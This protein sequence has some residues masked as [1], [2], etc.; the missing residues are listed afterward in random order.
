MLTHPKETGDILYFSSLWK[1]LVLFFL[2][3]LNAEAPLSESLPL[4]FWSSA[5]GEWAWSA[6]A[7]PS[8]YEAK[9]ILCYFII[10][11]SRIKLLIVWWGLL[12]ALSL[13]QE[14]QYYVFWK[15]TSYHYVF[16]KVKM[17]HFHQGSPEFLAREQLKFNPFCGILSFHFIFLIRQFNVLLMNSNPREPANYFKRL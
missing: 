8:L 16:Y 1:N 2:F 17:I 10:T 15:R 6:F 13:C 11:R 9:S 3:S 7:S 12:W 4:K 5:Q 14:Y